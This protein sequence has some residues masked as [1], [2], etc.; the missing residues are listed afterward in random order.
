MSEIRCGYSALGRE[1]ERGLNIVHKTDGGK[2]IVLIDAPF[3]FAM[4]ELA[5]V[6]CSRSVVITDNPCPEYWEDLWDMK[7][8]VLLARGTLLAEIQTALEQAVRGESFRRTPNAL[9]KLNKSE[10][11]VLQLCAAGFETD[12]IA[13]KLNLK[14]RTARNYLSQIFEKLDIKS[15]VEIPLYY[16]GMWHWLE[17]YR[18]NTDRY[19][20]KL[21]QTSL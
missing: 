7:P 11:K 1:I 3:G 6:D 12:A 2:L 15:R 10:R 21:G 9:S 18:E 4:K 5:E 20:G 16:W 8:Q 14:S 13:A 17:A 19:T